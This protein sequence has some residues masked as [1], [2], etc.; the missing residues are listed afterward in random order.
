LYRCPGSRITD[1]NVL[2]F[3]E[4]DYHAIII[5]D[6]IEINFSVMHHAEAFSGKMHKVSPS[7]LFYQLKP[8]PLGQVREIWLS[9]Q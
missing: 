3:S 9:Q 7:G 2:W 5:T 8:G 6:G 4:C 1:G